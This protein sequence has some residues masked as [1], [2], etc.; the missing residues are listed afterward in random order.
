MAGTEESVKLSQVLGQIE[1]ASSAGGQRRKEKSTRRVPAQAQL[2]EFLA[3]KRAVVT[4]KSKDGRLLALAGESGSITVYSL[5]PTDNVAG[6]P[7]PK[8]IA[9]FGAHLGLGL[10]GTLAMRFSP[11]GRWL[12]TV[13]EDG[14]LRL[15]EARTGLLV[16]QS[17]QG[18][19]AIDSNDFVPNQ[20][21]GL[22]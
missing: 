9:S 16:V 20:T 19:I 12:A 4:D 8:E 18:G 14:W 5:S 2:V 3:G 22:Q 7:K 21:A 6:K 17:R 11:D 1:R 13:G 10:G 15:W